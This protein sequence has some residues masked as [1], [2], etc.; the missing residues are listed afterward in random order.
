MEFNAWLNNIVWG[1]LILVLI[2][3]TGLY[4]TIGTGAIA[5]NKLG[6]IL[7][8]TVCKIFSKVT[9]GEGE[10]TP[11][12]VLSTAIAATVGG[13]MYYLEMSLCMNEANMI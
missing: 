2:V 10:V 3:G 11:F 12:Q 13:P 6:F 4:L 7:K 9:K 8:N 1:P 5:W